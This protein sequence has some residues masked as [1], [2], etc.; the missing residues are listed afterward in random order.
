MIPP[1]EHTAGDGWSTYHIPVLCDEV[2][3]LLLTDREGL[4]IDG[5]TGGG[6]HAERLCGL[7]EGKGELLCMD[8]DDEALAA[9]RERLSPCRRARFVQANFRT[10][11]SSLEAV[12]PRRPSGILLDLGVSSHQ[13]DTTDRGF[14]FRGDAPLDMRFDRRQSFSALDVVN[15]YDEARLA[16]ILFRFGEERAS[17]AIARRIIGARPVTSTA[18]LASAVEIAV[19]QRFLLKSLARVF[20]AIRIEVNQELDSLR[21]TLLEG[22]KLLVPGGRFVVIAYHSLE[23]RI[24]KE[25]FRELSATFVPSGNKLVPD[26]VVNPVLRVVTK[27]PLLPSPA[28]ARK[29]PRARSAKMRVAERMPQ[30]T[31]VDENHA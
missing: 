22:A 3:S 13:I 24:V 4:Y 15:T 21:Q 29:N 12:S 16:E 19:G 20:Q 23:D 31:A 27:H 30:S 9:A 10:L 17:R 14:S 7:L 11:R 6:G 25:S 5:T 1:E 2:V 26:R 28:E 18:Q 8:A